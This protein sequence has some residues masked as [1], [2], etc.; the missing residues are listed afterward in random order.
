MAAWRGVIAWSLVVAA[1]VPLAAQRRGGEAELLGQ[2]RPGA[3][4]LPPGA[5]VVRDVAYGPDPRQRFD[6]YIPA[7]ASA[8][9]VVFMVHGGGWRR[10][11]KGLPSVVQG[12]VTRWVGAG[13]VVISTNYRMIPDADPV[14]Q[15]RDVAR[16][17]A[18]AQR[19][20]AGW[21]ADRGRFVLM[22]HSAGA[23]LIA[24]LQSSSAVTAGLALTPWLGIVVLDSGALDV[25]AIMEQRHFPLFDQAFGRDPAF[26]RRASPL[27]AMSGRGAPI[28]A[29]C[30]SRR[31]TSCDQARAFVARAS[32]LGTR[33]S[34]LPEDLTH[35]DINQTLGQAGPYTASVD[36]FLRSL[37]P[38][39]ASALD[40]HPA[41]RGAAGSGRRRWRLRR[42]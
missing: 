6:V 40:A 22:G 12:K 39:L 11:D 4:T 24:L 35:R 41:P 16:A 21:G 30:S 25:P 18:E 32:Q 2:D 15:A 19:R 36:G 7:G 42:G 37:H 38:S 31:A 13:F 20:A 23:H 26:W 34:V 27:H 8:A 10:G 33:A 28:L 17:L 14:E 5:R 1:T 9:P 29:V 3:V